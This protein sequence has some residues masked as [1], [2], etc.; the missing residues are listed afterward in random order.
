MARERDPWKEQMW[1]RLIADWTTSEL[2]I[3]EFCRRRELSESSF[4]AWR[5]ELR[6]RDAEVHAQERVARPASSRNF[7]LGQRGRSETR[8]TLPLIVPVEVEH[9]RATTPT[10][11]EVVLPDGHT[12]RVRP[13]YDRATFAWMLAAL[14]GRPH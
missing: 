14:E 13:G 8:S 12:I 6:R 9:D 2:S 5:R 4:N 3:R 10:A 1:R 7:E 11:L